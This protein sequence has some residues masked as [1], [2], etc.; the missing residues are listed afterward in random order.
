MKGDVTME[1][2]KQT[3]ENAKVMDKKPFDI[4]AITDTL[5]SDPIKLDINDIAHTPASVVVRL[6]REDYSKK[7]IPTTIMRQYHVYPI[8]RD[9]ML[10]LKEN[11]A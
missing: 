3:Y 11:Q 6:S 1:E 7:R 10:I 9:D 2:L 8:C 5:L 4:D